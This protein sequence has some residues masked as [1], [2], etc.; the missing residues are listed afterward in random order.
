MRSLYATLLAVMLYAIVSV[1]AAQDD[2]TSGNSTVVNTRKIL[3]YA[4][5]LLPADWS[6]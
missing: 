5:P 4:G 6:L 3:T 2:Q 1:N